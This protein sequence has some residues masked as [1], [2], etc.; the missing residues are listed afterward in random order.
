MSRSMAWWR[1]GA[2]RCAQDSNAYQIL[3]PDEMM[4]PF[5]CD[6]QTARQTRKIKID[7]EKSVGPQS[8]ASA[9]DR[10]AIQKA[11]AERAA[12]MEARLFM[13]KRCSVIRRASSLPHPVAPPNKTRV[14]RGPLLLGWCHLHLPSGGLLMPAILIF[15]THN[16]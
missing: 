4:A 6:G 16:N 14:S 10:M 11:L 5:N 1:A 12:T 15:V 2:S 7:R 8:A 9:L 3:V 13:N